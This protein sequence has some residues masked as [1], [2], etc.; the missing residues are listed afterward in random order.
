ML[1]L[2]TNTLLEEKIYNTKNIDFVNKIVDNYSNY[3]DLEIQ[4]SCKEIFSEEVLDNIKN[5]MEV[6]VSRHM[7]LMI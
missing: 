2:Q 3:Y 7:F 5:N 1:K 4:K 6:K